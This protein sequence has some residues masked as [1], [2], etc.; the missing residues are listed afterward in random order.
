MAIKNPFEEVNANNLDNDEILNYWIKPEGIFNKQLEGIKLTGLIPLFLFGGRG[1]GKTTVLKYIS[2]ELQQK[3]FLKTHKNLNGFLEKNNFLGIY[4]RFDGPQL[5]AFNAGPDDRKCLEA[6]RLYIELVLSQNFLWMVEELLTNKAISTKFN[7]HKLCNDVCELI[8][9][10]K[11]ASLNTISKIRKRLGNIQYSL[12]EA[13]DQSAIHGKE[14]EIKNVIPRGR[15]IFELQNEFS[16]I[17]PELKNTKILYLFDE[18]EN[19]NL[20][21][22]LLFNTLVKHRKYNVSFKIGSRLKGVKTYDTLTT[23]EYLRESADYRSVIFEDVLSPSSEEYKKILIKI[24]EKRLEHHP[25]FYKNRIID[26]KKILG[27]SISPEQES[28]LILTSSKDKFK[29]FYKTEKG[30]KVAINKK[31]L[32]MLKCE[33]QPLIEKLNML[34]LNRSYSVSKIESMM[35][36]FIS[37]NKESDLY[38]Q[39]KNLYEKNKVALLFQ[40]IADYRPRDKL[41]VGFDTYA[42][43]SSGVIRTFLEL[44]F[45]AFHLALFAEKENLLSGKPISIDIQNDAAQLMSEK[46]FNEISSIPKGYGSVVTRLV[47]NVGS[48]FRGL[49]KDPLLSEPEPTY[50]TTEYENLDFKTKDVL[51]TAERWSILQRTR[52]MKPKE[53]SQAHLTDYHLN[54]MLCPK[55]SISYRR[56]GRTLISSSNLNLLSFGNEIEQKHT[57]EL[58]SKEKEIRK[59]RKVKDQGQPKIID[60]LD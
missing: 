21:Q 10:K 48:V 6:F 14:I 5:D 25:E 38:K 45:H 50:F 13:R 40:L 57:R 26:I 29:H 34:L 56:R 16:K 59:A 49:H 30:S 18:Y 9:G 47:D 54:R 55:Y 39:Y 41:Y 15:L 19:L 23:E 44:C 20:K 42:S 36:A 28:K 11:I 53:R 1:T 32:N 17:I 35:H 3:E 8:F 43:M 4:H 12:E 22:Q 24:A 46:Y 52:S 7:E 60:Y 51:D 27:T 2:F 37:K 58:I 31:T 33:G